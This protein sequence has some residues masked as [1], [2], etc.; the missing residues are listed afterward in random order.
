MHA[1]DAGAGFAFSPCTYEADLALD[2]GLLTGSPPIVDAMSSAGFQLEDQPGL[3]KRGSR[4]QVD[5]LVPRA[6][7]EPGRRAARLG[8]HGNR[9]AMRVRGLEGAFVS[10]APRTI[11]S[12]AADADRSCILKVAGPSALLVS[13]MHKIGE[14]LEDRDRRRR[15]QL[16]KD[17]SDI[18]RLLRAID[19]ADLGSE[20]DLHTISSGRRRSPGSS[21][22]GATRAR[23]FAG[24]SP[25]GK[26]RM[27]S[28][29]G[30]GCLE[31]GLACER[32]SNCLERAL[33][34]VAM[35]AVGDSL[36]LTSGSGDP[37]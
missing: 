1:E 5:L 16:A 2:P 18:Y 28:D 17:A 33:R 8:V 35:R 34:D 20:S 26:V 23:R 21:G 27:L 10:H 12:L 6:V 36:S 31:P 13:K 4:G 19:T 14:R 15:D 32:D 25:A 7:G 3:Y 9:A 11:T 30:S 29:E 24:R 22:H 37:S